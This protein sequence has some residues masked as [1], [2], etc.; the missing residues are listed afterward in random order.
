M[1]RMYAS[2]Q[3]D[4][5]ARLRQLDSVDTVGLQYVMTSCTANI[6]PVATF[7]DFSLSDSWRARDAPYACVAV[8]TGVGQHAWRVRNRRSRADGNARSFCFITPS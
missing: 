7:R 8:D 6:R 2:R 3:D 1:P 5:N 4:D